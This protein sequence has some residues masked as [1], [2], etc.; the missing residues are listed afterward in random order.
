MSLQT[1]ACPTCGSRKTLA[2]AQPGEKVHCTCGMSY[3]A[4]PVFEVHD[5]KEAPPGLRWSLIVAVSVLAGGV[6]S[7]GWL[8]T[9]PKPQ[10]TGEDLAK[11]MTSQIDQTPTSHPTP[12][13]PEPDP[14]PE[15]PPAAVP[16]EKNPPPPETKVTPPAPP[17]PPVASLSAVTIW[18]AFD[19]D[20][21]AADERF[22]GK[23][24]EI[25]ARG[26]MM[27][28]TLGR[29]YFGAVVVQRGGRKPA[30]LSPEVQQWE[31]EGYPASVRCYPAADQ[32]A[33][34]EQLPTDG[35]VVLRGTCAGR[36]DLDAVY[37]GYVVDLTD[38][39]VV[40]AK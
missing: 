12:E 20:R 28:D 31:N 15:T 18:D 35:E 16:A 22:T 10:P 17:S 9:R 36:K 2:D 33:A 13:P 26:K 39:T 37:R 7:A 5:T 25:I 24:V 3:P 38:C 34:F 6:V 11:S 29:S 1:Y 30:R 14:T 32:A 27:E 19:L 21:A 4:S 8:M 40:G 23:R